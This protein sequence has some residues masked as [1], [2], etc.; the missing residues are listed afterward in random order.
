MNAKLLRYS[1]Q[2]HQA[3]IS[4]PAFDAAKVSEVNLRVERQLLLAQASTFTK[5]ANIRTDY[6]PPVHARTKGN[7]DYS[8]QGL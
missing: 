7:K 3:W 2:D 4:S 6:G 5:L 8:L 1:N